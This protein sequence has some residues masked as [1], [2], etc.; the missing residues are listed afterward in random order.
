M[1]L[2][3]GI[4]ILLCLVWEKKKAVFAPYQKR[5][6]TYGKITLV[7]HI[8]QYFSE[9]T[10]PLSYNTMYDNPSFTLSGDR[11]PSRKQHLLDNRNEYFKIMCFMPEMCGFPIVQAT[12]I[13]SM[14][15]GFNP[16]LYFLH[17]FLFVLCIFTFFYTFSI[18]NV[19]IPLVVSCIHIVLFFWHQLHKIHYTVAIQKDN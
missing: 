6:P 2:Y 8:S 15:T 11:L 14:S 12:H 5:H 13:V 1:V 3:S 7:S 4:T 19:D 16:L 9:W 18:F 17:F 10:T